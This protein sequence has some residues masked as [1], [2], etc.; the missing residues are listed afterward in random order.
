M[1]RRIEHRSE[2]AY[3]AERVYAALTNEAFLRERLSE[4]GGRRSELV[5]FTADDGTT[6]AKMRQSIDAEHLPAMVRRV[7]SDGVIIDRTETWT[8]PADQDGEGWYA[9]TVE[10]KVSGFGGTLR[11]TTALADAE[12]AD[13]DGSVLSLDGEVR[14]DLPLVGGRIEGVVADELGRL[15]RAEA[16]FTDRWLERLERLERD[17]G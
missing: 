16:R 15:L 7:T 3:P 10:A 14:V 12:G 4:I 6:T 1:A 17:Q 8:A 9:G 13:A 11:G 5:S 2:F